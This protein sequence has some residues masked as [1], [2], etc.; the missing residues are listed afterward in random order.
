MSK[1]TCPKSCYT[2]D[3]EGKPGAE[4]ARAKDAREEDTRAKD[5]RAED[6]RAEDAARERFLKNSTVNPKL[7]KQTKRQIKPQISIKNHKR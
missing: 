4:D 2:S 6:A 3:T 5:A 7:I 1:T